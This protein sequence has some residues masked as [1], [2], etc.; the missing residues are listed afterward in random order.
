MKRIFKYASDLH[1]EKLTTL[2]SV[3]DLFE[4]EK[5]PNTR[6]FLAIPGDIGNFDML[7]KFFAKLSQVYERV[8]YVPGNHEYHYR[9]H[10][11][12]ILTMDQISQS[13]KQICDKY[14]NITYLNNGYYQL[15][16]YRIIGSTFW[17][18]V[19]EH[20]A[21]KISDSWCDYFGIFIDD[22]KEKKRQLH[23]KD[24]TKIH[25]ESVQYI[26][27]LLKSTPEGE[28]NV[29]LTHH[30]PLYSDKSKGRYTSN[31]DH[32]GSSITNVFQ[33]DQRS[34]M[35]KEHNIKAWIFGH[36][37]YC[38]KFTYN[39]VLVAS[40][41][42]GYQ[43]KD[44]TSGQDIEFE[45]SLAI[46]RTSTTLD[47]LEA[48]KDEQTKK[49]QLME[50]TLSDL[51]KY[52]LSDQQKQRRDTLEKQLNE[53]VKKQLK[54][55]ELE[56]D[57]L[58]RKLLALY[59]KRDIIAQKK[60]NAQD[61]IEGA[62]SLPLANS[63]DIRLDSLDGEQ[64]VGADSIKTTETTTTTTTSPTPTPTFITTDQTITNNEDDDLTNSIASHS[65]SIV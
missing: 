47:K 44:V 6:Y 60:V 30:A 40:N 7:D 22:E 24:S 2:S 18:K 16:E 51:S 20:E 10:S 15:D 19:K 8:F 34:L 14:P 56:I 12:T 64:M 1:L 3:K 27:E 29:I 31:P 38:T 62:I 63:Q 25:E 17:T 26:L 58:T 35:V 54:D 5:E 11:Q 55:T 37:H 28:K 49:L 32:I 33:S 50:K 61:G 21:D 43:Y 41:Q 48:Q 23:A 45:L 13:L 42:L 39:N 52:E 4:F 65:N 36:T 57:E 9:Y 53:V 59:N 46:N